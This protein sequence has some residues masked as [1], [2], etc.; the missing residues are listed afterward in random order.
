M[1][2]TESESSSVTDPVGSTAA[3]DPFLCPRDKKL[4]RYLVLIFAGGSKFGSS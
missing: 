3:I 4:S 1:C 2:S